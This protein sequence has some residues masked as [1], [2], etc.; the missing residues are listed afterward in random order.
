MRRRRAIIFDD[1]PSVLELLDA[2]L[3]RR[4]YE[5]M[6]FSK[7]VVCPIYE[8]NETTCTNEYPC[9]DVIITD[10][11]MPKMTGIELLKKQMEYGC[12]LSSKNKALISAYLDDEAQKSIEQLGCSYLS[13]PFRISTLSLWL[14]DCEKRIDLSMPLGIRRKEKRTPLHM[15][16]HYQ[17]DSQGQTM[18][19]VAADFSPSGLCLKTSHDFLKEQLVRLASSLPNACSAGHARWSRRSDDGLYLTGFSC[20]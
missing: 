3:S 7:P 10:F 1:E 13:K 16:V 14:D 12:R 9:A 20:C 11:N 19:G 18:T 2:V 17:V 6:S 15:A 5:V 4:G 8:N